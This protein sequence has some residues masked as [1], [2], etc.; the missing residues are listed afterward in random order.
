MPF[1]STLPLASS[2]VSSAELRAQFNGL[3]DL[4]DTMALQIAAQQTQIDAMQ[5]QLA[6]FPAD[7]ASQAGVNDSLGNFESA[8][9]ANIDSVPPLT[10][11]LADPPTTSNLQEVVDT[12]NLILTTAHR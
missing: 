9:A 4:I 12:V 7:P 2:Q 3:K 10:L 1:N 8:S 5:A 11:V 6:T